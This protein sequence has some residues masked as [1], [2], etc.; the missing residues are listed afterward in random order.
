MPVAAVMVGRAPPTLA[1]CGLLIGLLCGLSRF[2]F[3]CNLRQDAKLSCSLWRV[4]CCAMCVPPPRT[5]RVGAP[6]SNRA[7]PIAAAIYIVLMPS[8]VR[9]LELMILNN[10]MRYISARCNSQNAVEFV[11]FPVIATEIYPVP[12]GWASSTV[13]LSQDVWNTAERISISARG[14]GHAV[15]AATTRAKRQERRPCRCCCCCFR[16]CG[17][18]QRAAPADA[19]L[20]PAARP[21]LRPIGAPLPPRASARLSAAGQRPRA[22]Q[23][24]RRRSSQRERARER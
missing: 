16:R 14:R 6:R 21:L 19:A 1:H 8:R 3:S 20:R 11:F 10:A 23:Q 4:V 9:I 12:T 15:Q 5:R 24:Q 22:R 13:E 2:P 17:T 7:T 18:Q